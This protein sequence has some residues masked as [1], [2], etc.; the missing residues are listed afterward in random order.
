MKFTA[1]IF[2]SCWQHWTFLCEDTKIIPTTTTLMW[3]C[4]EAFWMASCE[5]CWRRTS[6]TTKDHLIVSVTAVTNRHFWKIRFWLINGRRIRI[7]RRMAFILHFVLNW[8][9]LNLVA[10]IKLRPELVV[11]GWIYLWNHQ[12]VSAWVSRYSNQSHFSL[13]ADYKN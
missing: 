3:R 6:K 5:K 1:K 2:F 4:F 13:C 11:L 10:K 8:T 7:S 9:S 12:S